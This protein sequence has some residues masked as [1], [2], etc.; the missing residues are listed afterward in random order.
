MKASQ[1]YYDLCTHYEQ[2]HDGDLS[3][4]GLQPKMDPRGIWTEGYGHAMIY[5]GEFLIGEE[6]KELA[7]KLHVID[8]IDDAIKYLHI[9][10][11]KVENS[12][13]SINLSMTQYEYDACTDFCYNLGFGRFLTSTL[14]KM[15]SKGA[16]P[17]SIEDHFVEWNKCQG[18]VLRGLTFRRESEAHLFNTGE[19]IFFN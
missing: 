11:R 1:L 7:Y 10:T 19:L 16:D 18:Q 14:L 9:D 4:I 6:N 5:K 15:I 3:M 12:L 17:Q 13:G 2:L 8:N